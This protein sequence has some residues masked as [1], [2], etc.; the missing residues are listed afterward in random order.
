MQIVE[1]ECDALSPINLA[2]ADRDRAIDLFRGSEQ[3]ARRIIETAGDAFVSVGAAGFVEAWNWAAEATFGWSAAEAIGRPLHELIIPPDLRAAHLRGLA[4]MIAGGQANILDQTLELTAL[5]RDRSAFPVELTVW[6][7]DD[8]DRRT[9]NAFVRD[10]SARK[11]AA[12]ATARL[13]AVVESSTEAIL[14]IDPSGTILT[15][16]AGAA[17][18]YGYGA[19]EMI[20]RNA[21]SV[22]APAGGDAERD[23]V[24]DRLGQGESTHRELT[25][26]RADGRAITVSVTSSPILD[27]DGRLIAVSSISRDISNRKVVERALAESEQRYRL[28]ADSATDIV[29]RV[30]P[31]TGLVLYLSPSVGSI[32]GWTPKE[33]IGTSFSALVHPECG[34]SQVDAVMASGDRFHVRVMQLRCRDGSWLWCESSSRTILDPT[35]GTSEIQS[36]IRDISERVEA[37]AALAASE[38]RFRVT[39]K[40]A[41]IGM[42]LVGMDGQW[43]QVNPALCELV[44]RPVQ[45]LLGLAFQDITHPDDL[46]EDLGLVDRLVRGD[47]RSYEIEKRYLRPDGEVVW[48][49]LSVSLVRSDAEPQYFI[50][51]ILDISARK[52]DEEALEV[53]AAKLV[54]LNHELGLLSRTDPLTGVFNRR[55]L[56]QTL[57]AACHVAQRHPDPVAVL[58]IDIDHFKQVNDDH[59]HRSG[60]DVLRVVTQRLQSALRAQDTLGRWGG[61]EFLVVL[62]RTEQVGAIMLAERLR[63]YVAD[64]LVPIGEGDPLEIT[65]SIGV[66]AAISPTPD[67]LLADAD[68]ALY[69]AKASGRNRVA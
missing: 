64:E 47:I 6:V 35:T 46:D 49:L 45:E 59:G 25:L 9:F 39:Q 51:Q 48:V 19:A 4:R 61:E 27:A 43:L 53:A 26:L 29:A 16:N 62:P 68:R 65:I 63:G 60:D 52:R 40:H 44:G 17:A 20:G 54:A 55:H 7:T 56:D 12:A 1:G 24:R 13:A 23:T 34:G 41:P 67:R 14:T 37:Q 21:A 42:A 2:L 31:T 15:W 18:I 38:E 69:A 50:A 30:S 8:D 32:L 10:I 22:L 3:R 66:A 11:A 28:L 33:L 58:I 57:A 36:S 5:R